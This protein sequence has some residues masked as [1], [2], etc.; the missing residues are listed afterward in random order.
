MSRTRVVGT[1]TSRGSWHGTT[2]QR[3]ERKVGREFAIDEGSQCELFAVFFGSFCHRKPPGN[4]EKENEPLHFYVR[5]NLADYDSIVQQAGWSC[6]K[7]RR[8]GRSFPQFSNR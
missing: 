3:G 4:E 2:K 8:R 1:Q 7:P 6:P 5:G